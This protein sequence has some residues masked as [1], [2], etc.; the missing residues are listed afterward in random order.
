[1]VTPDEA[2]HRAATA[3]NAAAD[4]FDAPE[5][6]FWDYHGRRT[7]DRLG[8]RPGARVLDLC[9]GSG[10]SAL[11][12]A[13][14]V[15]PDGF[16]LGI[17][18]AERLLTLARAKAAKR[19]LT[20]IEFRTGDMLDLG[21][22]AASFDAV[23]CVFGIFF[24]PDMAQAVRELWRLVR[25]GG[26][27]AITTW[28]RDFFEPADSLFWDAVRSVRPNLYKGFNPWDRIDDSTGLRAM[29]AEG[30]IREVE[31]NTENYSHPLK[32]PDD[33]WTI[34]RG[35]GYRGTIDLL[36]LEEQALVRES[37]L[38]PLREGKV[39]SIEASALYAIAV[40]QS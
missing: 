19:G 13:E 17:D 16:V 21:L 20:N 29:L 8:L 7:I 33:W 37:N 9:S 28:G 14:R 12:A 32:S 1:M 35:C 34:A 5:L 10:A 15:G 18:L 24:V 38:V 25:P 22:P 30:G 23:V 40:K 4:L 31:I 26:K 2:K 27:L 3:Y 6:G 11:P 36:S 39:S